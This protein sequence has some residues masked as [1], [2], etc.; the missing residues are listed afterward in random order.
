ME[1]IWKE[2]KDYPNYQ[3]SNLGRVKNKKRILK[4]YCNDKGYLYVSL[5]KDNKRKFVRVH[6][7][8]AMTFIPN[9]NNLP[10]VNHIDENKTN[11]YVT[12]LE[13]IN[14]IENVR[15][16]TGIIKAN[17]SS[18]VKVAQYDLNGNEIKIWNSCKEI[19]EKYRNIHL[20]EALN[21]RRKTAKGYIWK[22]YE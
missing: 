10:E 17:E 12:N 18:Y 8:V 6:R 16:G 19:K 9:I 22:Y 1:E 20:W 3:I 15:Y 4:Q 21:G 5:S 2:I 13:W 7:L 11:N 14:H